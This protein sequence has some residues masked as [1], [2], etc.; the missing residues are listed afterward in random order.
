MIVH[1]VAGGPETELP[2][3]MAQQNVLWIGVDRGALYLLDRGI[4]PDRAVGD[5]DSVTKEEWARIQQAVVNPVQYPAEKDETDLEIALNEAL[6]LEPEAVYLYGVTGGRLDHFFGAV[7]LLEKAAHHCPVSIV[8]CQNELALFKPG[9]Y[10]LTEKPDWLYVSFFSVSAQVKGLT[11]EGFRYP[12]NGYTVK[13]GSSRCVSNELTG[14]KAV[15]SF[16]SGILMM[17]RSRDR[18]NAS[19]GFTQ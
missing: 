7:T 17:I 12:L 10:E 19:C 8:D 16:E 2:V 9:T 6:S 18:G 11:L 5:F 4:V 15:F 3:L 13:S 1:I 14:E